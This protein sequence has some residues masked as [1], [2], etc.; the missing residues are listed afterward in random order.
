MNI[1][2]PISEYEK[3][4]LEIVKCKFDG[5]VHPGE[6]GDNSNSVMIKHFSFFEMCKILEGHP[7]AW[8]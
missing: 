4:I 5:Y 2:K 6:S 8:M 3:I 7:W 1:I